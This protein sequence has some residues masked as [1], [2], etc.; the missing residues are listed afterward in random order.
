[1]AIKKIVCLMANDN[2][3]CSGT[4]EKVLEFCKE[5]LPKHFDNISE[6]GES[7]ERRLD[8]YVTKYRIEVFLLDTE[9]LENAWRLAKE[10]NQL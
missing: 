8:G 7:E 10:N 3:P 9:K 2:I 4:M 1:M 6:K 5:Y